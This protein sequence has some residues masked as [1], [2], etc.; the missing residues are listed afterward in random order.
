MR[1]LTA[2]R[3]ARTAASTGAVR[4]LER[5]RGRTAG[6]RRRGA[7]LAETTLALVVVA[8]LFSSGARVASGF[9]DRQTVQRTAGQLSRLAD[10][11]GEWAEAEFHRLHPQVWADPDRVVERSWAQLIAARD[12]STPTVPVTPLRQ[13]V[14]VFLHAPDA[15]NLYVVLLTDSPTGRAVGRVPRPDANARLVGRVDPHAP[16][17][18]RGWAF[19]YGIRP[20]IRAAGERFTGELGVIRQVSDRLHVSPYLHRFAVAGRPELNRMEAPLEMNGYDITGAGDLDAREAV[21]SGALTVEGDITAGTLTVNGGL[22]VTGALTAASAEAGEVTASAVFADALS[23]NTAVIETATTASL[24]VSGAGDI[25]TLV[26]DDTLT[27]DTLKLEDV[28]LDHLTVRGSLRAGSIIT[29][30]LATSSCSG[31]Q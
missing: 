14:R 5:V 31:C 16:D 7:G 20:I 17:E 27:V 29:N 6:F 30:T 15:D 19:T 21:I 2:A 10:D 22:D 28:G 1:T 18:L 8:L 26:V 23:A 3:T 12:V 11:V 24:A 9:M 4:A 25:G 13:D